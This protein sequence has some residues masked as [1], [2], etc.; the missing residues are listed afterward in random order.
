MKAHIFERA[1]P[2]YQEGAITPILGRYAPL[3]KTPNRG[4]YMTAIAGV[5]LTNITLIDSTV[6]V[7]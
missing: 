7:L 4:R 6:L 2:L 5:L 1:C 3:K